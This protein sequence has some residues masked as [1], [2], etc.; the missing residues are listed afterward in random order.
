MFR[1]S[2]RPKSYARSLRSLLHQWC[3]SWIVAGVTV[4]AQ[5]RETA[6][7]NRSKKKGRGPLGHNRGRFSFRPEMVEAVQG[8]ECGLG[9]SVANGRELGSARRAR[10]GFR[11]E[12]AP[13]R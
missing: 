5:D 11:K 2:C 9:K 1:T 10:C 8:L 3:A 13:K 7:P 4:V 6:W 12:A